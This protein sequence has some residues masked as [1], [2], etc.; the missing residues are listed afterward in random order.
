MFYTQ[1][2]DFSNLSRHK[3]KKPR[4]KYLSFFHFTVSC[5]EVE[6]IQILRNSTQFLRYLYSSILVFFSG[7]QNVINLYSSHEGKKY[8]AFQ[9]I[10]KT[11]NSWLK[12]CFCIERFTIGLAMKIFSR[13]WVAFLAFFYLIMPS[14]SAVQATDL[15]LFI[16]KKTK[17][18]SIINNKRMLSVIFS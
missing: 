5:H 17:L 7:K 11:P 12:F 1:T 13:K 6:R 2:A 15:Q 9:F 16:R 3:G 14:G 10:A 4:R 8:F 18:E